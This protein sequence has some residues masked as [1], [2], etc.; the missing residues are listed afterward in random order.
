[1]KQ[2]QKQPLGYDVD[3]RSKFISITLF[4]IGTL[5]LL[6]SCSQP[7]SAVDSTNSK[8][9]AAIVEPS[10]GASQF[11]ILIIANDMQI[12]TPR[13]PI[14]IRDGQHMAQGIDQLSLTVFSIS[15]E[16]AAENA[17]VWEGSA[18]G[19][20]DYAVPYWVFY[21]TIKTAGNYGIKAD[22]I[23]SNGE[24][25]E[26]Q[27]AVAI[28]EKAIAPAVGDAGIPS[29]SRTA[30]DTDTIK[31]IS[32]DFQ[33]PDPD[34]YTLTL[35]QALAN[36]RPTVISFSTPAYCK[37]AFC[38]P[39]LETVKQVKAKHAEYDFIHIEIFDD[40]QELTTHQTIKDWQLQSEP[41]T[42]V[43]DANGIVTGRFGGP[44]SVS[45]LETHLGGGQ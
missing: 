42:Y 32:S 1:M 39:V 31:E 2:E 4:L 15:P 19:Y 36:S 35:A 12:G 27:F 37:T 17:P 8:G 25:A 13:I 16:G 14:V 18:T 6:T 21:P 3:M 10:S 24:A 40:F 11:Q 23:L 33:N 7:S 29:E 43:L 20:T 41:W 9:G 45:E 26:A 22:M 44:V 28:G 34:L 30:F 38:A 5:P